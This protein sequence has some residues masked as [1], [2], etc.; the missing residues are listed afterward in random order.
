MGSCSMVVKH[1]P[2]AH[3]AALQ[4]R[5][6]PSITA[7]EKEGALP[8]YS[9]LSLRTAKGKGTHP[10]GNPSERA[11]FLACGSGLLSVTR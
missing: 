6:D 7:R 11:P 3:G 1:R 4:G 5:L 2:V 10:W 9:I 8:H